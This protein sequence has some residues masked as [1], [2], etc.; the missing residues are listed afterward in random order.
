MTGYEDLFAGLFGGPSQGTFPRPAAS[1]SKPGRPLPQIRGR[2]IDGVLYVR[3]DDVADA[4]AT[5]APGVN[6][7]LIA[8]LRRQP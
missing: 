1:P 5:Q 2:V 4:L 7:R 8:K 6:R 3:A